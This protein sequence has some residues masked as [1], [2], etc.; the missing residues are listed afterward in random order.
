MPG[1][2]KY[3]VTESTL[4]TLN[5]ILTT[6]FPEHAWRGATSATQGVQNQED[7][8]LT[9]CI[10]TEMQIIPKPSRHQGQPKRQHPVLLQTMSSAYMSSCTCHPAQSTNVRVS[11]EALAR[12]CFQRRF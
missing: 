6:V 11:P 1:S 12:C 3:T 5:E 9:L 2:L 8:K 7:L 10:P 4:Q